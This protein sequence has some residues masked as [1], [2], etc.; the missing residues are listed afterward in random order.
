MNNCINLGELPVSEEALVLPFTASATGT[1]AFMA[2]FNGAY[3]YVQFQATAG[4]ALTI[5]VHLNESYTYSI[6]LFKPDNSLFNDTAYCISTISM[7]AD[8]EYACNHEPGVYIRETRAGKKQFTATEG[9]ADITN[10]VLKNALQVVVFV[11]G[12]ILQ[13]GTDPDNYSFD[14]LH[15]TVHFNTP[16]SNG[17]RITI[18]YFK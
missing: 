14:T 18:L 10:D 13:E 5:P 17:Q 2:G 7:L 15:G 11:E 3:Q 9:Q 1:W 6:K 8:I 12:T 16:L 4:Q